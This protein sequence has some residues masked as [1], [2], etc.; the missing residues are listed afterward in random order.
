MGRC[1]RRHLSTP[2]SVYGPLCASRPK[3]IFPAPFSVC[4]PIPLSFSPFSSSLAE[5]PSARIQAFSLLRS[6]AP[7]A[8]R[9]FDFLAENVFP[10]LWP[11]L[12]RIYTADGTTSPRLPGVEPPRDN[13]APFCIPPAPPPCRL[14][15]CRHGRHLI[16][17]TR[18]CTHL[19]HRSVSLFPDPFPKVFFVYWYGP[20]HSLERQRP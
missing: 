8:H 11:P 7:W 17:T 20:S 3:L 10:P 2:S 14:I 13:L 12:G 15:T 18:I 4:R 16:G 6:I 1:L 19:G 5:E 9:L